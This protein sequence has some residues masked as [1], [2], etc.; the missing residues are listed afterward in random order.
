M[1]S[2][3]H[4]MNFINRVEFSEKGI[5]ALEEA[6][7]GFCFR[8][9]NLCALLNYADKITFMLMGQDHNESPYYESFITDFWNIIDEGRSD[10]E[11]FNED[12]SVREVIHLT[13]WEEF[14]DYWKE[15]FE[16]DN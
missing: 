14:Y 4:F 5:K 11:I 7:E 2:K 9:N 1:I 13:C 16:N 8:E 6:F 12:G 3:S 15:I 10:F